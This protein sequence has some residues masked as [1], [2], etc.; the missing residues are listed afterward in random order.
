MDLASTHDWITAQIAATKAQIATLNAAADAAQPDYKPHRW[1]ER[2]MAD[3]IIGPLNRVLANH[4][5]AL[6]KAVG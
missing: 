2:D 6:A 4:A 3:Q 5:D 1:P